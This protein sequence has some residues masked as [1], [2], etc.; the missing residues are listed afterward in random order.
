MAEVPNIKL[1]SGALM[2]GFGFGT[3]QLDDGQEAYDATSAALKAGYRL[4]DTARIYGNE[5][6]VGEAVRDSGI[7][8]DEIFVTTKLWNSDRGY[9]SGLQAFEESLARLGL[10]YIDLY[11]IHW[12]GHDAQARRDAWRALEEIE[13]SGRSKSIGV[14]N[15]MVSHLEELLS[16][17]N[18]PPSV[19][20]IEFHPFI[21]DEQAPVLDVCAKHHIAVEAYS[22]LA[23]GKKIEHPVIS[24]VAKQASRSNAQVML[25][26]ALQHKTIPIP[27]SSN[28]DH[29]KENFKVFDF[30]L[31]KQHMEKIDQIGGSESALPFY[32]KLLK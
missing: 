6:S 16:Y 28:P 10:D 11:L 12:P 27:R 23:M 4:I 5:Q 1:N 26:W 8:R 22:P 17:A 7:E 20:Q 32:A 21:F 19:N 14:S 18:T 29:T 25:R 9:K 30:E 31:S 13:V 15:Y 3:W 24:E 2:P